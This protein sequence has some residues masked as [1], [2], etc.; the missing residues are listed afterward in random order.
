MYFVLQILNLSQLQQLEQICTCMMNKLQRHVYLRYNGLAR[1]KQTYVSYC[2]LA[3]TRVVFFYHWTTR[4]I[5]LLYLSCTWIRQPSKP[6]RRNS[7]ISTIANIMIP[8]LNFRSQIGFNSK[9]TSKVSVE[10]WRCIQR[11]VKL[12]IV[13]AP[14]VDHISNRPTMMI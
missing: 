14:E 5:A 8:D 2:R 10:T 13:M 9:L 3:E 12:T 4:F 1:R 6:P 7:L 11:K